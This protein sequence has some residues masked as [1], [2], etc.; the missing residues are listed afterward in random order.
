MFNE[1]LLKISLAFIALLILFGIFMLN[2]ALKDDD[3]RSSYENIPQQKSAKRSTNANEVSLDTI[4]I[5]IKSPK[6]KILKADI[7]LEMKS[8][9][10]KKALQGNM[11]NVRNVMLRYLNE[12]EAKGLET[13]EGKDRLKEELITLLEE[14]FGYDVERIYLKNFILSP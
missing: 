11:Q 4:Y 13:N 6:F 10:S 2:Y 12:M 5:N 9:E 1:R 7:A 8:A 3:S 14:N